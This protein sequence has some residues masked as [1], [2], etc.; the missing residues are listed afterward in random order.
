MNRATFDA[1]LLSGVGVLSAVVKAGNFLRAAQSMGLTQPAVSRAVS[2][3]EQRLG[4]K[5]FHRTSRSVTLTE[6]GR[7]FYE[8]VAPLLAGIEAA[9]IDARETTGSV[10][11]LLRISVDR[12]FSR[13]VLTPALRPFLAAHPDLTVEIVVQDRFGD[14]IS[15]GLD[16]GVHS[17]DPRPT[18][19]LCDRLMDVAVVTC[20]SPAYLAE[21]GMPA[22]PRDIEQGHECVLMRNPAT[23]R[24]FDWEF[25]RGEEVVRVT[26]SGRLTVNDPGS[27]I[28]GC[29]GGQGIGQPLEIYV[30]QHLADGRLVRVLPDW[31]DETFPVHL[32]HHRPEFSP[33]RVKVFLRFLQQTVEAYSRNVT[34]QA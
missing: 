15:D 30:R 1:R 17:G 12:I 5:L 27:L 13:Y 26:A 24:P 23:G 3:L 6:D 31:S 18:S 10:H 25:V 21:R 8:A 11:G 28:G 32:Y 29:L 19:L 14:L 34:A 20:A 4:V 22:R 2:R 7:R 16:L 33:E 9:A